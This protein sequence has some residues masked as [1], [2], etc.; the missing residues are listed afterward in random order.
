M[1]TCSI[2]LISPPGGG[3]R[4]NMTRIKGDGIDFVAGLTRAIK[5]SPLSQ[6]ALAIKAGV[7]A[8]NL[9]K[10]LNLKVGCSS[11]W[12]GKICSALGST[13]KELIKK[14]AAIREDE[15]VARKPE[16]ADLPGKNEAQEPQP[17]GGYTARTKPR[18]QVLR[19]TFA[20]AMEALTS[21][22]TQALEGDAKLTYW[23]DVF[24]YLP[25]S[26]CIVRDGVVLYQN[27]EN[28]RIC[29][30]ATIGEP[31]C[32]SCKHNLGVQPKCPECAVRITAETGTPSTTYAQFDGGYYA[33]D[34]RMVKI[35]DLDYQLV[36]AH[37]IDACGEVKRELAEERKKT[38]TIR[39]IMSLLPAYYTDKNKQVVAQ[40][41]A[42]LDR[43]AIKQGDIGNTDAFI[44]LLSSKSVSIDKIYTLTKAAREQGTPGECHID[45][46]GKTVWL[47]FRAV[48][49]EDGALCGVLTYALDEEEYGFLRGRGM[50]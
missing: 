3:E 38:S 48:Q 32:D 50:V 27:Q 21:I 37:R 43:F 31:L 11:G 1:P 22:A 36:V 13:E 9:S 23:Q 40:S 5:E 25:A 24:E 17:P 45:L 47:V 14:G 29:T 8:Q 6:E 44:D 30:G 39:S 10:V 20:T 33:V 42:F 2:N 18:G 7:S 35:T 12:R 16:V 4:G 26:F 46:G 28:R 15:G 49:D 19:D 34:S 41:P